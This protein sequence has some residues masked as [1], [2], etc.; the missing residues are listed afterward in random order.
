MVYGEIDSS[1]IIEI[2]GGMTHS[3][4]DNIYLKHLDNDAFTGIRNI[5]L[6]LF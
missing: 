1:L 2:L 3:L 4:G 6:G 5:L